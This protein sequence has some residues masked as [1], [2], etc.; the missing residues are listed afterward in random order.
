MLGFHIQTNTNDNISKS[1]SVGVDSRMDLRKRG[2]YFIENGMSA[3][4]STLCEGVAPTGNTP[5]IMFFH[6][7]VSIPILFVIF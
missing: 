3:I 4:G 2:K 6:S 7:F 1:H 5:V